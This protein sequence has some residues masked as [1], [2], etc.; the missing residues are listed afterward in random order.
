MQRH[1]NSDQVIHVLRARCRVDSCLLAAQ[2]SIGNQIQSLSC[3]QG[4]TWFPGML[5]QY[6]LQQLLVAATARRSGEVRGAE[7][8]GAPAEH[9]RSERRGPAHVVHGAAGAGAAAA[10][11]ISVACGRAGP[12]R[13]VRSR[14]R[15]ALP[16]TRC[17]AVGAPT[18]R[19]AAGGAP[20]VSCS[21]RCLARGQSRAFRWRDAGTYFLQARLSEVKDHPR[22]ARGEAT[23]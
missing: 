11:P 19:A 13:S 10:R 14:N 1:V 12:A 5:K 21:T 15:S 20:A 8:W 2:H 16:A 4:L 3:M 23:K 18:G 22:S 6:L 7:G 17:A 9:G